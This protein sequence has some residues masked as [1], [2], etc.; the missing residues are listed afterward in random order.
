[1]SIKRITISVPADVADR[2]KK[3]AGDTPVSTWV[4][5]LVE[6]HLDDAELELQWQRFYEDVNPTRDDSKKAQAK[7]KRLPS[8]RLDVGAR[9]ERR[10]PVSSWM[11]EHSCALERRNRHGGN[12]PSCVADSRTPLVLRGG[13]RPGLA[14]RSTTGSAGLPASA[15]H[16]RPTSPTPSLGRWTVL[17]A[18]EHPIL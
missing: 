17:G 16:G 4:T 14:G 13:G 11:P 12:S 7:F 9:R 18:A 6:E 10:T 2:I 8:A 3:A 1:M 15:N 5:E